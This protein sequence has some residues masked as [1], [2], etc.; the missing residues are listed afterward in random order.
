MQVLRKQPTNKGPEQW[1]TGH[2]WFDVVA[3][4]EPPARLRMNTVRFAPCA[5]T[6]WHSHALGQTLHVTPDRSM[7]HQALW[8]GDDTTWG[9]LVTDEEYGWPDG[10]AGT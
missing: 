9:D 7:V 2:V 4:A 8:E 3:R 5:R 10:A 6:A 1:S